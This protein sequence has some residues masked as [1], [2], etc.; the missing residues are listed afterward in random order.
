MGLKWHDWGRPVQQQ[1]L[2]FIL[3]KNNVLL[4]LPVLTRAVTPSE[5]P[6]FKLFG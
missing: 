3:S 4:P 1:S 5:P 6:G 2:V